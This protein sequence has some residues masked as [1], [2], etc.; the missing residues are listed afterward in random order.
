M[1]IL[2]VLNARNGRHYHRKFVYVI[3]RPQEAKQKMTPW[4]EYSPGT[5]IL[6]V[7]PFN[8]GQD[9][10]LRRFFRQEGIRH[11]LTESADNPE[12]WHSRN[13]ERRSGKDL[14]GRQHHQKTSSQEDDLTEI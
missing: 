13:I 11:K 8:G 5:R 2:Y 1:F 10:I 6:I 3:A 4:T 14:T 12:I 9:H 7:P